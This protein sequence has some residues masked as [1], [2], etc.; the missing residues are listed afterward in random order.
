MVNNFLRK[1]F[2]A[3]NITFRLIAVAFFVVGIVLV[4]SHQSQPEQINTRFLIQLE[5]KPPERETILQNRNLA[6]YEIGDSFCVTVELSEIP[7]CDA[8]TEKARKFI[9]SRWKAKKRAYIVYEWSGTDRGGE[10]HIFI[11]PDDYGNW[12]IVERTEF[13]YPTLSKSDY[14]QIVSKDIRTIKRKIVKDEDCCWR[15]LG[16]YYLSLLDKD[17]KEVEGI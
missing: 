16:R 13:S 14:I 11:E 1:R 17:A 10:H 9:L 3:R 2:V 8:K 6:D 4:R 7:K 12:H 5:P 15:K